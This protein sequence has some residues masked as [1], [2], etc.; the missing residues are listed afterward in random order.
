M[1]T[2]QDLMTSDV[3]SAAPSAKLREVMGIM[4]RYACRQ[5]PIVQG[6]RLVGIVSSRDVRLM[7]DSPVLDE[8]MA[9]RR[10]L[11]D[12]L[13]ASNCMTTDVVTVKP[14]TPLVRAAELLNLYKFNAV[15]VIDEFHRLV[16]ILSVTDILAFFVAKSDVLERLA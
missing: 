8:D 7:V 13:R 3:Y 12:S 1:L 9:K 14:A 2:V 6:E 15:P 10:S 16:G 11:L 5:V 4:N